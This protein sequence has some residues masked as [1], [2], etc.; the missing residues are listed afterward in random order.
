[1]AALT[2]DG[3]DDLETLSLNGQAPGTPVT[4][5]IQ[6]GSGLASDIVATARFV[7]ADGL[8]TYV[9]R[10][11]AD[12]DGKGTFDF[13]G[14]RQM[15]CL[16]GGSTATVMSCSAGCSLFVRVTQ[17][18]HARV[19]SGVHGSRLRSYT[20]LSTDEWF[21][22]SMCSVDLNADGRLDHVVCAPRAVPI[23]TVTAGTTGCPTSDPLTLSYLGTPRLGQSLPIQVA[24]GPPAP[25]IAIILQG[26]KTANVNLAPFGMVGCS[27]SV[28]VE[29]T[30]AFAMSGS[31]TLPLLL[32][33]DGTLLCGLD[34]V[35]QAVALDRTANML[36]VSA[37]NRGIA[38]IGF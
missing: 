18:G 14:A 17:P 13:L 10:L 8:D 31:G 3:R 12:M 37:T 4:G 38:T 30:F 35:H 6:L 28:A 29:T 36:G 33:R 1:L 11:E 20:A 21:G 27:M 16:V 7:S 26:L 32:P 15:Q 34:L 5:T 24:N 22:F 25:T 19:Y 2:A 9:I 23:P